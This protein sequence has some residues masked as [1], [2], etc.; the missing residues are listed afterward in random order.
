MFAKFYHVLHANSCGLNETASALLYAPDRNRY[1]QPGSNAKSPLE[2]PL[3]AH[4]RL[5]C[6]WGTERWDHRPVQTWVTLR[7]TLLSPAIGSIIRRTHVEPDRDRIGYRFAL[8]E[9]IEHEHRSIAHLIR[10]LT[11]LTIT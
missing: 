4:N 11:D 7:V 3:K 1:D 5:S 6:T 8:L 9:I 10:P 2:H